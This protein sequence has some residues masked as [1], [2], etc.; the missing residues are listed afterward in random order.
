MEIAVFGFDPT[1]EALETSLREAAEQGFPSFWMPQIFGMDALTAIAVA[2][3]DVPNIKVGTSVIPT[4]PRHPMVLAQQALTTQSVIGGRLQLGIGLSHQPVVEGMWGISFD[5]PVRH[6]SDY[7][8]ILTPLLND[9]RVS[10]SG[11]ALTGRGEITP[12]PADAPPVLVAALGPQ[13]LRLAGRVADG[14]ITW[15]TG[16]KTIRTLTA[17]TIN[18]AAQEA[19]R[20]A[21]EVMM[22]LPVCVTDDVDAARERADRDYAI[23]GQLPSYRA[24]LDREG[25]ATPADV[26]I[27]GDAGEVAG[28]IAALADCGVTTFAASA[29]GSPDELAATREVMISLL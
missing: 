3:K 9:R 4:Y 26:A 19:G 17:P 1:V 28:R 12:P 24:M 7:L 6:M 14:T 23:Y 25:A 27:I 20:P 2:A 21:P 11:E 5:K 16:P 22:G 8:S 13:M 29:F 15:M 10:F 18:T